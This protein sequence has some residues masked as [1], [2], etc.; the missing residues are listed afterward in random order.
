[1]MV[2]NTHL[3]EYLAPV[4]QKVDNVIHQINHCLLGSEIGLASVYP[5]D[6]GLS[7]G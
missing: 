6:S 2:F 3:N 4:V 5:L 1:M 7:G